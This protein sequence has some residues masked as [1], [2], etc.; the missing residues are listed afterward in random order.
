MPTPRLPGQSAS[1]DPSLGGSIR[2]IVKDAH[3]WGGNGS[4]PD[5]D[6]IRRVLVT[7]HPDVIAKAFGGSGDVAASWMFDNW[8]FV[9]GKLYACKDGSR[10]HTCWRNSGGDKKTDL[11]A[12][13]LSDA[14]VKTLILDDSVTHELFF[15]DGAVEADPDGDLIWK[16]VLPTGSWKIHPNAVKRSRGEKFEITKSDLETMIHNFEERAWEHVT[17]PKTHDDRVDENT[18]FTKKLAIVEHPKEPGQYMMRAGLHFTDADI[19]KKVLE[20][21]I[22]NVSCGLDWGKVTRTRDGK[23]FEKVIK[24]IALTPAPWMKGLRPFGNP[25]DMIAASEP[26]DWGASLVRDNDETEVREGSEVTNTFMDRLKQVIKDHTKD[27][28]AA[29]EALDGLTVPENLTP[30]QAEEYLSELASLLEADKPDESDGDTPPIDPDSEAD[31]DPDPTGSVDNPDTNEGGD[32]TMSDKDKD[33]KDDEDKITLSAEQ[34]NTQVNEAVDKAVAA[35]LAAADKANE[36]KLSE[37]QQENHE[38]KVKD[39]V[40]DLEAAGHV[41]AVI[42]VAK[43]IM[44]ADVSGSDMLTFSEGEGDDEAEVKLSATG[45]VERLLDAIPE[46]TL[47]K[48]SDKN[49]STFKKP[50]AD[51]GDKKATKEDLDKEL[52]EL[53][54]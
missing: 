49:S 29:N 2:N 51:S 28:E 19:K 50:D 17:I 14:Q 10:K 48:F 35:A 30:E 43:E 45:I 22:P 13:Q 16:D 7:K 5:W 15:A 52:D 1:P 31:S 32:I 4:E 8:A 12:T 42:K 36:I 3:K 24:H 41:P 37:L 6:K 38:R 11:D 39:S 47:L 21:S 53:R 27:P 26:G 25:E 46:N 40:R 20:G 44:L 54:S 18:G 34:L 33:N 9:H 23:V